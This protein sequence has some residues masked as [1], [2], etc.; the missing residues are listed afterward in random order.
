MVARHHETLLIQSRTEYSHFRRLRLNK[1]GT[2]EGI[3]TTRALKG[4]T[5]PTGML[6]VF[7]T[8]TFVSVIYLTNQTKEMYC[9]VLYNPKSGRVD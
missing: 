5:K 6:S 4:V 9:S 2:V 3:R 8:W 7:D 1:I